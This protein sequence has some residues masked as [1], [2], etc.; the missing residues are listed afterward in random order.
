M[1]KLSIGTNVPP[2]HQKC[3][4]LDWTLII[5]WTAPLLFILVEAISTNSQQNWEF[6]LAVSGP[7]SH[8]ASSLH[9]RASTCVYGWHGELCS[10]TMFPGSISR[11][12]SYLFL[13]QSL[14]WTWSSHTS[15]TLFWPC[16]SLTEMSPGF[17]LIAKLLSIF[18]SQSL[19]LSKVLFLYPILLLTCC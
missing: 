15:S 9:D 1:C 16:P 3:R 14:L 18:I 2:Y 7:C 8:V 4:L 13:M 6:W 10:L 19:C 17:L 11:T 5:S 12:E